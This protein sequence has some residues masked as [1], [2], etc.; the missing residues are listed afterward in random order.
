MCARP[1]DEDGLVRVLFW[2]YNQKGTRGVLTMD[3]IIEIRE[4]ARITRSKTNHNRI[5]HTETSGG[6]GH[7]RSNR[8]TGLMCVSLFSIATRENIN[9][10]QPSEHFEFISILFLLRLPITSGPCLWQI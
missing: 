7:G 9:L 2:A 3:E 10:H 5:K 4:S 1:S 6:Q 8:M